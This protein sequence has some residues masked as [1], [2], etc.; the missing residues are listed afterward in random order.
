M[1]NFPSVKWKKY[2]EGEQLSESPPTERQFFLKEIMNIHHVVIETDGVLTD[3]YFAEFYHIDDFLKQFLNR[4]VKGVT[5]SYYKLSQIEL[6]EWM[7][8]H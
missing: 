6:T 7:L 3:L 5:C 1:S 8:I 4:R 2:I